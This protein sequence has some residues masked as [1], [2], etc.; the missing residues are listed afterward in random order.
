MEP[1]ISSFSLGFKKIINPS[2]R[3]ILFNSFSIGERL[4]R[5]PLTKKNKLIQSF[6][7]CIPNEEII[8]INKIRR[9][10]IHRRR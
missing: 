2:D 1:I 3:D 8:N 10:S 4:N 9:V 6:S 7:V 5:I